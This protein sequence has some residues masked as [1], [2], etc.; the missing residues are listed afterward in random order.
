MDC[1]MPIMNGFEATKVIKRYIH[2]GIVK[3]IQISACTAFSHEK[4]LKAC[5]DSGMDDVL[6]KPV[7]KELLE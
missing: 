4:D 3:P 1:D 7:S 5:Y 2:K 6:L